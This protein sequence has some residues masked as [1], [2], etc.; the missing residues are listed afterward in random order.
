MIDDGLGFS[1]IPWT[2]ILER[3][4]GRQVFGVASATGVEWS[5]GRKRD[6]GLG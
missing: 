3:H 6:L 4:L 5:F 2:P 1:L